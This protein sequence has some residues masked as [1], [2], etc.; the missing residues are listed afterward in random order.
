VQDADR[1]GRVGVADRGGE[2]QRA[3]RVRADLDAGPAQGAVLQASALQSADAAHEAMRVRFYQRME[4]V[5]E[6]LMVAARA[7]G[8][9]R[10]DV[11]AADILHAMALL[12]QPVPGEEP[13]YSQRL[14]GIFVAGL[15]P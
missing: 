11:A 14:V 8:E 5:L 2:H 10:A 15:R 1:V 12:C 6:T 7:A 13:G 3:E 4:P 9:I